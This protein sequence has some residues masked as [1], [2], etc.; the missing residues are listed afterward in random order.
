MASR[1]S[2]D[3]LVSVFPFILIVALFILF[4]QYGSVNRCYECIEV[5]DWGKVQPLTASISYKVNGTNPGSFHADFINSEGFLIR[6]T[7]ISIAD[8][9]NKTSHECFIE[10]VKGVNESS[11]WANASVNESREWIDVSIK[12]REVFEVTAICPTKKRGESFDLEIN[13][14]YTTNLAGSN[15]EYTEKGRIIG[16]VKYYSAPRA[17]NA[18]S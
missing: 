5:K 9:V 2:L 7:G 17:G 4:W 12:G 6:I 15:N 11:T 13:M 14:T 3:K 1:G 10:A 18:S 8:I 16:P